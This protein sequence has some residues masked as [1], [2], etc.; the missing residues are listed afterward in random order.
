MANYQQPIC[1][2]GK[3]LQVKGNRYQRDHKT[4]QISI[5]YCD[6]TDKSKSFVC[7]TDTKRKEFIKNNFF[8]FLSSQTY[9]NLNAK[10]NPVK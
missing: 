5:E 10:E 3:D 7:A 2:D 8:Y 4:I 6:E 9:A 1:L